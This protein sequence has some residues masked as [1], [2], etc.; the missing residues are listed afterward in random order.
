MKLLGDV[1]HVEC[2]LFL[3][4]DSI[5]VGARL[6]MVCAKHTIGSEIILD[7]PDGT[8]QWRGTRENLFLSVWSANFD[9]R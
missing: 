1:G 2:H 8:P 4:G 9:A 5:S 6:C 3:F 7:A